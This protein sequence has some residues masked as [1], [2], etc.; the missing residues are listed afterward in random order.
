[1]SG[2]GNKY[3][4]YSTKERVLLIQLVTE[5][6]VIENKRTD[7]ASAM[8]KKMAWKLIARN[9]NCQ[10][11][12]NNIRTSEQLKK[13][14][15]NLKQR[16]RKETTALR[17]S[18]LA[19]GGGPLIKPERDGVLEFV[20]EAAPNIDVSIDCPFD[21]T[22]VCEKAQ[23]Q[24]HQP[25]SSIA[26]SSVASD[27]PYFFPTTEFKEMDLLYNTCSVT[28]AVH[29][30]E[31]DYFVLQSA[32]TPTSSRALGVIPQI[33][34]EHKQRSK[35]TID[36][37]RHQEEIHKMRMKILEVDMLRAKALQEAA[38]KDRQRATDEAEL[39][40]LKLLDYKN[41]SRTQDKVESTGTDNKLLLLDI[42]EVTH[43]IYE[44]ILKED[45]STEN[46][47]LSCSTSSDNA[48]SQN[49]TEVSISINGRNP[50][51]SEASNVENYEDTCSL[52][53]LEDNPLFY[54]EIDDHNIISTVGHTM[55]LDE[56]LLAAATS[57]IDS[58]KMINEN[59]DDIPVLESSNRVNEMPAI[60]TDTE[61]T[62]L[63]KPD[64]NRHEENTLTSMENKTDKTSREVLNTP[65]LRNPNQN[66]VGDPDFTPELNAA[67]TSS[68]NNS[69]KAVE[70]KRKKRQFVNT[71]DWSENKRKQRR[72]RGKE[73][74][75]RKLIE[76]K[77]KY[78][79]K[80]EAKK[81]KEPCNCKAS[82]K[83]KSLK[84]RMFSEEERKQIF[85]AFWSDMGWKERKMY[86]SL[87]IDSKAP[88]R[89]RNRTTECKSRRNETLVYYLKINEERQ[90][91]CKQMFLNTHCVKENMIL[92]WLKNSKVKVKNVEKAVI[93]T[94]RYKNMKQELKQFFNKLPKV[95]SHYCRASSSKLYLEP[96]WHS[97]FSLYSFYKDWCNQH[98]QSFLSIASFTHVFEEMNL[99]LFRT[100][101]DEC[102]KCVAHK[103]GNLTDDE[104]NLH[105]T[106]K[107]E[108][109]TEKS[110][111][112]ESD[113]KV[114][115]MDLQSVL[116]SP[117]SNVS[118]LYFKTKLIVH[119]FTFFD[120]KTS[121]GYCY[122]WHES[123]GGVTA[124]DYASIICQFIVDHVKVDMKT[125]QK[126]IIYSDG[127]TSQNR[128]SILAN[129]L[130]NLSITL[131]INIEQKFLEK[132]HTQMEADS[133][134]S[135]I[136]R[137]IRTTNINVPADYVRICMKARQKP[138]PYKVYYLEYSFF[139]DFRKI[140]FMTSLRPG[141]KIGDPLVTEI[142][143]LRYTPDGS[144]F[145]K[146]RHPDTF[147]ELNFSRVSKKKRIETACL[148]NNLPNLYDSP[149]PIK[150]EKYL[151]LQSLK[152][153]L[154]SDYHCFYDN[155][156]FN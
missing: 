76:G 156:P 137:Q 126:L 105:Q 141:K 82:L 97:K 46:I 44:S 95:E 32:N 43:G 49:E 74:I 79:I 69:N 121:N 42:P 133:I 147:V 16:K 26:R 72:E 146:L 107:E 138:K 148:L 91:V 86:V 113:N 51:Q 108:A 22:A 68:D 109:R 73:Y 67:N 104:F 75:G 64:E 78:D 106:K 71:D 122:I 66:S 101:K 13:L 23:E 142:R 136:E 33:F 27:P 3:A 39:A 154:E 132:G 36:T 18:M 143:A 153:S 10:P 111:D 29:T 129:A 131:N 135:T 11:E 62:N 21:S 85:N 116:L 118:S 70:R 35:K 9:Y 110:T 100:K 128:N 99:S 7:N 17:H 139:K 28:P 57:Q 48:I 87:L 63:V 150:R 15:N 89:N 55:E 77:W 24:L 12:V 96:N 152:K 149:R 92:D 134:H 144:V 4:P 151:H 93:K 40:S 6:P 19:T 47:K 94:N 38:E 58:F 124:S 8:E 84:C 90:R 103:T 130:L 34:S 119:N 14:W 65:M 117:K 53:N 120:L 80:R 98:N 127:C 81:M 83:G 20:E 88:Q 56:E 41:G 61:I 125:D 52:A 37:I 155:L 59:E 54:V 60:D 25:G 2:N 31:D 114:Y 112:K 1:M 115:C 45:E 102:D 50:N 123:A 30:E 145:Y 140:Q 5:N